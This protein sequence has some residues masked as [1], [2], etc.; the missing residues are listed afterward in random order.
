MSKRNYAYDTAYES[1]P[2]Q[3]KRREERNAA[4]AKMERLGHASKGDGRD[5]DHRNHNTSD[6]SLSNIHMMSASANRAKH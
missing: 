2:R 5:V 4:R 1:N 6:N 3:V